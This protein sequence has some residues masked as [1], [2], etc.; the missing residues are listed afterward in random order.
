MS[1]F[2]FLALLLDE[3]FEART[4]SDFQYEGRGQKY[5]EYSGQSLKLAYVTL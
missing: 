5:W 4:I 3:Y 1:V 2:A